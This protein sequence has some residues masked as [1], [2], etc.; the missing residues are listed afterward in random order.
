M[1][2]IG[3]VA[4]AGLAAVVA[5]TG[6]VSAA[7]A[8]N[9]AG[10]PG[11]VVQG[12]PVAVALS[13]TQAPSAFVAPQFRTTAFATFHTPA[14]VTID[15]RGLAQVAQVR[16]GAGCVAKGL[17]AT[18]ADTLDGD[19]ASD[20]R[21]L[22]RTGFTAS[23]R[24]GVKPGAHGSYVIRATS[25]LWHGSVTQD[26]QV[27]IGA[28]K[29]LPA[30]LVD[31]QGL[32]VGSTVSEQVSFT[33]H[34]DRP[35]AGAEV[36][37]Q[38]TPGMSFARSYRNCDYVSPTGWDF[39]MA[40]CHFPGTT[41]VPGETVAF[42]QPVAFK[43]GRT[44]RDAGLRVV[45]L[46]DAD[47]NFALWGG[48]VHRGTGAPLGL[49]VVRRGPVTRVTPSH[50]PTIGSASLLGTIAHFWAR[51]TSDLGLAVGALHGKQGDVVTADVVLFNNGP[52]GVWNDPRIGFRFVAPPGT[53]VT[54]PG[55]NCHLENP[56][57]AGT[58]VCDNAA[59]LLFAPNGRVDW[60]F[61]LRV[62][63]VLPGATGR[64][65]LLSHLPYDPNPRNDSAPVVLN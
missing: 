13:A 36:L 42:A 51:N 17:V 32:T 58:Y 38:L 41:V 55:G 12:P 63:R 26:G 19:G 56:A 18:C 33:N 52:A 45:T 29:L 24:A 22:S 37:L 20:G 44:V 15:A 9:A 35:S 57:V 30:P 16:F 27:Q 11:P 59:G 48:T 50:L 2:V 4:G 39:S 5:A 14:T 28:P 21:I 31:H 34:G 1:R 60:P 6:L 10:R 3:R 8:A 43:V 46:P 25:P 65:E 54:S 40:L 7:P 23:I 49:K 47:P 64:V 53:S 61:Q 62:D